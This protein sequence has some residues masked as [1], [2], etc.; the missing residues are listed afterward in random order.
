METAKKISQLE[1]ENLGPAGSV[2]DAHSKYSNTLD[3]KTFSEK[4]LSEIIAAILPR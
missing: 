4:I 3:Q 2:Y 1:T